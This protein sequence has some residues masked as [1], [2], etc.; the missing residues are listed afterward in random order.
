MV[1]MEMG[2]ALKNFPVDQ[3]FFLSELVLWPT[4]LSVENF[5]YLGTHFQVQGAKNLTRLLL[6]D[7]Y[8]STVKFCILVN[9][10]MPS[11]LS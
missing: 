1:G 6:K 9:P 2:L 7:L 10:S 11:F 4:D 3:L 5:D 8:R